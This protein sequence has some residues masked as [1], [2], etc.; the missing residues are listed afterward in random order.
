MN[1]ATGQSVH[2]RQTGCLMSG[3]FWMACCTEE[4]LKREQKC[5]K[6][7]KH[8]IFWIFFYLNQILICPSKIYEQNFASFP[9]I[10]ARILMFKHFLGDWAYAEP[11][12]FWEIS[13]NFFVK[14]FTLV[15]LDSFL[16][17][18][19]KF[20]FFIGEIYILIRD[21]WVIFKNYS[22]RMLSIRGNNFVACWA[23]AEPISSHAEPTRNKFPRMLSQR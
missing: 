3:V 18:F 5:L 4:S 15:L 20:L 11:K 23:Y 1:S 6:V 10:F 21:F 7:H 19:S 14:I 12:F 2:E 8:E 22:M 17:S 16:A 13:K 9:S